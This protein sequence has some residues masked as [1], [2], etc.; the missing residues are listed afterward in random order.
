MVNVF[1]CVHCLSVS[2]NEKSAAWDFIFSVKLA[3]SWQQML[4]QQSVQ[5]TFHLCFVGQDKGLTDIFLPCAS[6]LR[7]K[8]NRQ[9]CSVMWDTAP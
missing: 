9:N 8:E 2:V 3:I 1:V 4:Q 7:R 5:R 6:W